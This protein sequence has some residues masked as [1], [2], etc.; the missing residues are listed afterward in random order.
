MGVVLVM[1]IDITPYCVVSIYI[2][3][4]Q[5]SKGRIGET[6][7]C[8]R[9]I[10]KSKLRLLGDGQQQQEDGKSFLSAQRLNQIISRVGEV[11]YN[12]IGFNPLFYHPHWLSIQ[13]SPVSSAVRA[14][15]IDITDKL[16]NMPKTKNQ[17]E[18]Q[19]GLDVR[20]HVLVDSL[21]F[22]TT[23]VIDNEVSGQPQEKQKSGKPWPLKSLRQRLVSKAEGVRGNS[24][25]ERCDF[26][27]RN[28]IDGDPKNLSTDQLIN[29]VYH[30]ILQKI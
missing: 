26:N 19:D 3:L 22:Y 29:L 20:E 2:L 6:N 17:L 13:V 4:M 23:T 10:D 8:A 9:I 11:D 14:S 7:I 27:A 1:N 15:D 5:L 30:V 25:G 12:I 18:C 24:I 28:A 16:Y 21:H